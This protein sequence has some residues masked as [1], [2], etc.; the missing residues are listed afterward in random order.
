M[1]TLTLCFLLMAF[2]Y[3]YSQ[4]TNSTDS[5]KTNPLQ[6][7]AW[8][9][10][11]QISNN[12]T[13]QSF[14]G[15]N[16]SL[17]RHFT[18][19]SAVRLSVSISG[20]STRINDDQYKDDFN[21]VVIDGISNDD[22]FS[23]NLNPQYLFYFNPNKNPVVYFG[24][25]PYVNYQTNTTDQQSNSYDTLYTSSK[26][27]RVSDQFSIGIKGVFGIEIFL[28]DF[29][30][31]HSEYTSSAYYNYRKSSNIYSTQPIQKRIQEYDAI[32]FEGNGVLFGLSVYF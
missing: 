2:S 12:F 10:Q 27:N 9:V 7:G 26:T 15:A 24:I 18:P 31:I 16:I 29:L 13:L 5:S 28:N 8:A 11:F 25:G 14:G 22:I 17:K 21:S 20:R 6:E 23:I 4:D 32:Y 30:S 1:R 19:N 3:L